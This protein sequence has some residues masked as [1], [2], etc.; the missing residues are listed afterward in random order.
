MKI[1]DLFCGIGGIRLGFE[2]NGFKTVYAND[3]DANCKKTYDLNFEDGLTLGDI[4]DIEI[5]ELPE[6]D[7]LTAGFACQSFSQAGEKKGMADKRAHVIYK[8]LDI[9]EQ[10]KPK[11]V[12]LENV[13][14][15][16]TVTNGEAYN[17]VR[18]KLTEMGYYIHDQI[19][20]TCEYTVIPQNRERIYIVAFKNKKHYDRFKFP[21]KKDAMKPVKKFLEKNVPDK[22]YYTEESAIYDKLK[23]VVKD[24]DTVYQ[25]RR[26]YV[27]ENKSGTCPTLTANMGT[28]GHNVP[29]ILDKKGIRKLTP[30][31][32]F[33]LQGFG[34]DYVLGD[35]ADAHLYKQ[36]G[37]S[38]TVP[39]IRRIAKRIKR[40]IKKNNKKNIIV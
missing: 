20:N 24:A 26:Y 2:K 31:E 33:N 8:M 6:F 14:N 30:R 29:I 4:H 18:D 34:K 39:V 38:V 28:G 17:Y 16:K 15:F 10:R 22:Y 21:E 23:D 35:L 40:A 11:V 1:I 36:A 37:N 32:C 9:I 19:M 12:F 25:Y 7:V 27:R 5:D 3:I 13:K